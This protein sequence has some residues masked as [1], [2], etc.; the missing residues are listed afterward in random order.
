VGRH[1]E[2]G[3]QMN[4]RDLKLIMLPFSLQLKRF[5]SVDYL[6][7][8]KILQCVMPD[9]IVHSFVLSIDVLDSCN[10]TFKSVSTIMLKTIRKVS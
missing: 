4:H 1:V 7:L 6:S 8:G 3:V 9:K 5:V 10:Q 2:S